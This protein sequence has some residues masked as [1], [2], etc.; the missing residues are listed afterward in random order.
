MSIIA[1]SK[2]RYNGGIKVKRAHGS[3]TVTT[4]WVYDAKDEKDPG[5]WVE[6]DGYGPTP[7]DR[8][9]YAI[10]KFIARTEKV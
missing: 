5:K 4:F 6:I 7:G 10:K 1:V 8:K 3:S 9:T 2:A